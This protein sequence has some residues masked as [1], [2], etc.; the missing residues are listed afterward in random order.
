LT[1]DWKTDD[2]EDNIWG[3][4]IGYEEGYDCK[5]IEEYNWNYS[6][7]TYDNDTMMP[8]TVVGPWGYEWTF[9]SP[10]DFQFLYPEWHQTFNDMLYGDMDSMTCYNDEYYTD[11]YGDDCE[12]YAENAD[13]CGDYDSTTWTANMACCACGG[14]SYEE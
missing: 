13:S 8:L 1:P 6:A 14:G 3:F 9:Y 4:F 5:Y 10:E 7:Y 12:W 11:D 2:K